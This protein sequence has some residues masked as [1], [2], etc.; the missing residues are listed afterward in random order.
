MQVFSVLNLG[1]VIR[2][3]GKLYS[4]R[5]TECEK[6]YPQVVEGEHGVDILECRVTG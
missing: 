2:I 5:S 4:A 1:F 6:I 3:I